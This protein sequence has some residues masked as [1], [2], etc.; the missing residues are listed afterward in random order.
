MAP[1]TP[2]P[3]LL[4][5]GLTCR[6]VRSER[7][8][9]LPEQAGLV[10]SAPVICG[11]AAS[12]AKQR[13][14]MSSFLITSKRG[15][16]GERGNTCAKATP[17]KRSP[18]QG[19]RQPASA[20]LGSS[21]PSC[22][23]RVSGDRASV[24]G[25][26]ADSEDPR[27]APPSGRSRGRAAG[28]L[29]LGVSRPRPPPPGRS[30]GPQAGSASGCRALGPHGRD[31]CCGEWVAGPSYVSRSRLHPGCTVKGHAFMSASK[32]LKVHFGE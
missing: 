20:F 2:R 31:P 8:R 17:P 14:M 9:R 16:R 26:G 12:S 5:A 32:P 23:G 1:F 27:V 6:Q 28:G 22:R 13:P 21:Y 24:F 25:C 4:P 10:A 11:A 3:L 15:R 7:R 29:C 30:R 18:W 19:P